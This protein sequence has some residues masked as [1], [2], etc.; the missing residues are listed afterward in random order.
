MTIILPGNLAIPPALPSLGYL[1][2]GTRARNP[3]KVQ[4]IRIPTE[5]N[6]HA[7]L[8][9][10]TIG[11]YLSCHCFG[12]T[13]FCSRS[14][15]TSG[16]LEA[17]QF[18]RLYRN[19]DGGPVAL[20]TAIVRY[21]PRQNQTKQPVHVD[22]VAAVHI[23]ER[24]YFSTLNKLFETYDA[25]LYELVAPPNARIPQAGGKPSGA[26]GTAQQGLTKLLG[27]Q[28]Q[29]DQIDYK[30]RNFVHADLSPRQFNAAMQRRGES[31]WTMFSKLMQESMNR[32][33]GEEK[34][35]PQTFHSV[36]L[37]LFWLQQ[38]TPHETT[39]RRA[40]L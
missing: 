30:P 35:I 8:I 33:N 38:R 13:R 34:R 28:F 25:V 15:I 7:D 40:I 10:A 18:L 31:W 20:E 19:E 4:V 12:S 3:A 24:E 14:E 5:K 1:S 26:I 23:G 39:T 36:I 29:L 17:P 21:S 22:L 37:A 9:D 2:R 32:V 6:C 16:I 11:A 27:L